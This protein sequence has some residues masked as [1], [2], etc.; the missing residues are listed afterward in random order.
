MII[1]LS[2]YNLKETNKGKPFNLIFLSSFEKY[3]LSHINKATKIIY[4][5]QGK[6]P[7]EKIL[8]SK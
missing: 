2:H 5:E 3:C 6:A 7:K 4:R 8:L 1:V